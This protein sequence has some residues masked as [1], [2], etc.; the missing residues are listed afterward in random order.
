MSLDN[1]ALIK[2][3][4]L[5]LIGRLTNPQ[6]Q[7]IWAL[8]PSLPK[9]WHLQ[10]RAVGSDLGNNCFQF[11]FEREDDLQ[12]VLDNRPYHFAYWMVILQRWEPIIS[13]AFPSMIP[14]WIRIKGL[15][16]HYWHD[17]MVRRV[18]QE[19]GKFET[20]VLTK[21]S[22]RVRVQVDGL[23]PLIKEYIVEFDSG[24]E[25]PITLEYE[26]LEMHC[27]LCY[28]L[29]HQR[30][31][32]PSKIVESQASEPP[33]VR[34]IEE[35]K[36]GRSYLSKPEESLSRQ[37]REPYEPSSKH[38]SQEARKGPEQQ[39]NTGKVQDTFKERVDR[40][41]VPFGQR[42][43]TKQ[44]R[45]PP[46]EPQTERESPKLT[47]RERTT[48]ENSKDYSSPSYTK[49]RQPTK[50]YSGRS[51]DLFPSRTKEQWRPKSTLNSDASPRGTNNHQTTEEG[52][53]N[54]TT[55]EQIM[56]INNQIPTREAVM[57]ELHEVTRQ[58]LSCSDPVEAA[59]RRQR[60]MYSDANGQMEETATAIIK[61]AKDKQKMFMQAST[62][63]SNPVTP[64]PIQGYDAQEIYHQEVAI[65]TTPTDR[66]ERPD[67][68]ADVRTELVPA[69]QTNPLSE[70]NQTAKLKSIIVSPMTNEEEESVK[71]NDTTEE[72][73]GEE[74]LVEAQTNGRRK[75][76]NSPRFR[77]PRRTH[78]IIMGASLKKRR[79]SQIQSSPGNSKRSATGNS[80]KGTTRPE[81]SR[82]STETS[83]TPKNP[84]IQLI[85]ARNK[86]KE[87]F[88]VPPPQAP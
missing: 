45:N 11:R 78:N 80:S 34:A 16:L 42:V 13:P 61:A 52:E 86:R 32:C 56:L 14:F 43:S 76:T 64:P 62:S 12:R 25:C 58:Y 31:H 21:T 70:R 4:E 88:Q 53:I 66:G 63:D 59:A 77:S 40:H 27:T 67:T 10:G 18:G 35:T 87:D 83:Q 17:D 26:R 54:P 8:I 23:K 6:I 73:E 19:L 82:R 29:L 41:G 65:I 57:E 69:N 68:E 50:V 85:P 79:M 48:H 84:P 46:P 37:T 2:A 55:Q 20:H 9:K 36:I 75:S 30:L 15:P 5:T 71:V 49:E 33:T 7:K 39:V 3:N 1:A 44:T 51:K 28:S 60:V 81:S 72:H 47:W 24:E 74:A 22:A 38:V